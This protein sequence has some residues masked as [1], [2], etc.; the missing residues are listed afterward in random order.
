MCTAIV[1]KFSRFPTATC[2]QVKKSVGDLAKAD[3]EGEN[4]MKLLGM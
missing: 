3:L 2:V 1:S 4:A